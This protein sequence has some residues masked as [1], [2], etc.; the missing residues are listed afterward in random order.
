MHTQDGMETGHDCH[1]KQ[2]LKVNQYLL[3]TLEAIPPGMNHHLKFHR[4][5]PFRKSLPLKGVKEGE[6]EIDHKVDIEDMARLVLKQQRAHQLVIQFDHQQET[7][8]R[9]VIAFTSPFGLAMVLLGREPEPEVEARLAACARNKNFAQRS[10]GAGAGTGDVGLV[11]KNNNC[12]LV[13]LGG[14]LEQF[15][16]SFDM[17][18]SNSLGGMLFG[19]TDLVVQQKFVGL[20]VVDV[21]GLENECACTK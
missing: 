9:V 13:S 20:A 21:Y 18:P 15:C 11:E 19:F 16:H 10:T 1:T 3:Q 4:S 14:S 2:L 17:Q 5:L 7:P 8:L 6:L 12:V